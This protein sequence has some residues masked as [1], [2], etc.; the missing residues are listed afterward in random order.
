M[1][2]SK[3]SV[4][5]L[6]GVFNHT[7]SFHTKE[8]ITIIH[9]PNG[10][11][12]TIILRMINGLFNNNLSVFFRIP[13]ESFRVDFTDKN[14]VVIQKSGG[15][16]AK[17]TFKSSLIDETI[18]LSS[19]S[20][21]DLEI[22]LGAIDDIIP[23]LSRVGA[24]E[25][26]DMRTGH[27]LNLDE[28]IEK[29]GDILEMRI[30]RDFARALPNRQMKKAL[31]P[32]QTH[33]IKAD[34]LRANVNFVPERVYRSSSIRRAASEPSISAVVENSQDLARRI[35]QTLA[36]SVELSS[37][38]DRSFPMRLV[39]VLGKRQRKL[40][41]EKIRKELAELEGKRARL[42]D[43]GLLDKEQG[44][45]EL[46]E[47]EVNEQTKLVLNIYIQDVKKKLAIFDEDLGR[48]E[49]FKDILSR[50]F[51]YKQFKIT[52]N[53][54]FLFTTLD[55]VDLMP[56]ALSS[57]EQHEIVLLYELLFRVKENSLILLDEPEISLHI[58]WQQEFLKD[59][60]AITQLSEF[61][62]LIATHSPDIIHD[63]WD[64]TVDLEGPKKQ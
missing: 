41:D 57:G 6:F 40:S 10:Y 48:I 23:E 62:A 1:K 17:L 50:R 58:G 54:G 14:F 44:E 3:V 13:F 28:I 20:A 36:K 7:I 37:S 63:R 42:V 56:D 15:E 8:R 43:A 22:P 33:L 11:G 35:Q 25:W 52:K 60:A 49:L 55:G 26:V 31:P 19:R 21:K 27:G 34:R 5:N 59:L 18:Q 2:V 29:Y 51:T 39:D 64:L 61:D 53:R 24:Q 4:K 46:P 12:K 38:L 45:F 47:K 9:G 30:G 32:I 16:K